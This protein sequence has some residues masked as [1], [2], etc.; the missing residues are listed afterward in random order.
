M[1]EQRLR[2]LPVVA[3][4]RTMK[5]LGVVKRTSLL[6]FSSTK[7][8]TPVLDIME[9]PRITISEDDRLDEAA[10]KL[11]NSDEWYAPALDSAYRLLGMLGLESIIEYMLQHESRVLEEPVKKYM[12]P[13]PV[14]VEPGMPIYRVWQYMLSK[15]LAALPV[16]EK[17]RIVGVIAE[18]D[19]LAHGYT[20]PVLESGQARKGP[21]VREV[22]STPPITLEPSAPLRE[23]AKIMVERDI[24]RVYVVLDDE[25]MG[26]LDRSDV[27]RAWI[28]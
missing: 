22:M 15:K 18:H 5:L 1:R 17:G 27:V 13:N 4:E 21:L 12:T 16:V 6:M 26:V 2:V 11:V 20:R 10:R 14:Y 25:L 7:V 19:L 23:A 9:E 28:K 8:D 3:D 24:G